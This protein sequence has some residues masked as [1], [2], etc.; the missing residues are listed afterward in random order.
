MCGIIVAVVVVILFRN[1]YHYSTVYSIMLLSSFYFVF[2]SGC[3]VLR[4]KGTWKRGKLE[5]QES[6]DRRKEKTQ[7]R[8]L[9]QDIDLL[10]TS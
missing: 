5:S 3:A 1:K 2:L 4:I 9:Y 10:Y 8:L 7:R 6:Q